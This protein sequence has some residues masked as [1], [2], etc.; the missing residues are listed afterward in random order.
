MSSFTAKTF[1]EKFIKNT[2]AQSVLLNIIFVGLLCYGAFVSL[3]K[4]PIDRYPNVE[5]G[6]VSIDTSYPGANA[7]EVERLVSQRIEES[8]RG[9]EDIEYIKSS[10]FPGSSK[11]YIKFDDDTDYDALYDELRLRVLGVQNT[12]PVINGD[13]LSPNFAKVNVDEWLPVVQLNIISKSKQNQLS[14]RSLHLLAKELRTYLNSI[15]GVKEVKINGAPYEEFHLILKRDKVL[16]HNLS[17]E[18]IINALRESGQ[19]YP[20]GTIETET[21]KNIINIDLRYR[22]RDDVLNVIV[23]TISD[24]NFIRIRD[25]CSFEKSTITLVN[26]SVILSVNGKN[27]V[28]C[29]I[30]KKSEGN[31]NTITE[32]A[33]RL[34]EQFIQGHPNEEIEIIP[35]LNSTVKIKD[36]MGV[37]QNSLIFSLVLVLVTLFLFLA[38]VSR[39]VIAITCAINVVGCLILINFHSHTTMQLIAIGASVLSVFY[40]CRGAILTVTGI[41]FSFFGSL[42]AFQL[43]GY[44]LNEITL[45]GFV[46]TTGI[47]VDDAIVVLENIQRYKEAGWS[48]RDAA[49]KGTSEVFKPVLSATLTTI[50][51]FLPMLMMTGSVGDFFALVPISVSIALAISL[52]ECFFTLPLH[53]IELD[54]WFGI[55]KLQQTEGTDIKALLA[56]TGITGKINRLY[57]KVLTWTLSHPFTSVGA[58]FI[59]FVMAV[60]VLVQ[61]MSA[62][63][64]GN[65]PILRFEFFP[66]DE[67]IVNVTIKTPQG[68]TIDQTDEI[69]KSICKTLIERGEKSI[70]NTTCLTGI[71]LDASYKAVFSSSFA[72]IQAEF[73]PKGNRSFTDAGN[74][75]KKIRKVLEDQYEKNGVE[76]SVQAAP[77]GPPIGAPVHIRILG[78]DHEQVMRLSNSIQEFLETESK[79]R[80]NGLIDLDNDSNRFDTSYF[81]E[82]DTDRAKKFPKDLRSIQEQIAFAFDGVYVGEYR[83]SDE[84]IPLKL[85]LEKENS[86]ND[87]FKHLLNL[88]LFHSDTA[89]SI[90]YQD[91]GSIQ[92]KQ[93][94]ATLIRRDYLRTVNIT[95]SFVELANISSFDVN[96]VVQDW[97]DENKQHY[98]G[99][100]IAFGGE[101]ESTKK[102]Y[103]SL[104]V[105]FGLALFLVYMVLAVQFQSYAQPLII[106]SN[107]IFSFTGVVLMMGTLGILIQI[108]PEGTVQDERAMFTVQ[109]FI[110]FI[111]LTGLVINDAIVFMDFINRT[112]KECSNLQEAILTSALQRLRPIVMTTCTTIA[113]LLPLAIGVPDFSITWGPFA[114][115]FVAGLMMSTFMTLLIIP[116][117]YEIQVNWISWFQRKF[118]LKNNV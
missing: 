76:I 85:K 69:S 9:M 62:P 82:I 24:G 61:S 94:A 25:I 19:S 47:I 105:A 100:K 67:S 49:V 80:L 2:L 7:E 115:C 35:T 81:F 78:V 22:S 95:G 113:G 114:T 109:S 90:Y 59:L 65:T 13:P 87:Y 29:K 63:L 32:E 60:L 42:I 96:K 33:L 55:G 92:E 104:F 23:K 46:I 27:S 93:T 117:I 30:L 12:L 51:A 66:A 43:L 20:A 39:T 98:S 28:S 21:G 6:E 89:G 77:D 16:E 10:S 1:V 17:T 5:F 68:T 84:D 44:S 26:Q 86:Q 64:K 107:I 79:N 37:L 108:L 106:M 75:I 50:F 73:P 88:P 110:A 34:A 41:A 52:A 40:S 72:F 4:L 57:H 91:I 58:A 3:P 83:R 71:T 111:G 54:Q 102:S 56:K 74:E 103:T 36:G 18:E 116:V 97:Y 11:L 38:Q 45:L 70:A 31:A 14:R 99:A 48:T 112:R 53:Y 15:D 8:I 101:S 118:P